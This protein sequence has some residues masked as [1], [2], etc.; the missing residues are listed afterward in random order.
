MFWLRNRHPQDWRDKVEHEH[1]DAP[2]WVAELDAGGKRARIRALA[3]SADDAP[4][5][6]DAGSP[7]P[8][9]KCIVAEAV[10]HILDR[11][12][13]VTEKPDGRRLSAT[14]L[15]RSVIEQWRRS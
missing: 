3:A 9:G 13:G 11:Q 4:A 15:R 6:D 2:R 1:R 12:V 7:P 14:N 8:L 10:V 5:H